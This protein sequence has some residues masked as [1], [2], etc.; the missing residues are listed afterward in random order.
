MPVSLKYPTLGKNLGKKTK[1]NNTKNGNLRH[2]H[3]TKQTER[4]R[5]REIKR[6]S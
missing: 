2:T 5:E 6:V 1:T 3:I 4:K